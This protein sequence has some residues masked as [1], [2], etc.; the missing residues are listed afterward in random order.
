MGGR[1]A[2]KEGGWF[3]LCSVAGFDI[4]SVESWGSNT[5]EFLLVVTVPQG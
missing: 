5:I 1:M 2:L 3:S 4:S